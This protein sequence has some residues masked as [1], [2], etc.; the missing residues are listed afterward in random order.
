MPKWLVTYQ[1]SILTV[2][3]LSTNL[4]RRT[5]TSLIEYSLLFSL[6]DAMLAMYMLSSY[7][8]LSFL[9]SVRLSQAGI[10][11]NEAALAWRLSDTVL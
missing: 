1:D 11:S 7:A 3:H 2:T 6:R 9:P 10:V 4:A 5:V 8:C